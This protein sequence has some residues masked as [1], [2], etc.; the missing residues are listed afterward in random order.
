MAAACAL[1][2]SAFCF[3]SNAAWAAFLLFSA[4]IAD[5]LTE[6]AETALV[7]AGVGEGFLGDPPPNS[8]KVPEPALGFLTTAFVAAGDAFLTALVPVGVA[9]F[10]LTALVPP[11][12]NRPE[13]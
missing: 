9:A 1:A 7:A 13:L 5:L 6:D 2:S 4:A 8:E 10:L 11:A 3:L 12:P